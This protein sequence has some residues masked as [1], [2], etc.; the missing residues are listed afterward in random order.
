MLRLL[1]LPFEW[2]LSEPTKQVS[3]RRR[4]A[5]GD[6]HLLPPV[7][8]HGD[9]DVVRDGAD[10][11]EDVEDLVAV[12]DDVEHPGSPLLRHAADVEPGARGVGEAHD[13]L[14]AQRQVAGGVAPVEPE[15]V[16]RRD[17][18]R[19]AH[20][21]EQRRAEAAVARGRAGRGEQRGHHQRAQRR[22][23]AQVGRPR[24]RV[25]EEGVVHRRHEGGDDHHGDARV[26][27]LPEHR[28]GAPR[29][30]RQQVR[31]RADG[32]ARHGPH[33][34]H[35]PRPPRHT[36]QRCPGVVVPRLAL[37]AIIGQSKQAIS[38][39][40]QRWPHSQQCH[41]SASCAARAQSSN[42]KVPDSLLGLN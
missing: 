36:G 12:A 13:D 23:G 3:L 24:R 10:E 28:A 20:G 16:Q 14:E 34:E 27:Q 41:A 30:A 26:V 11:H 38:Q 17:D 6:G 18:A 40:K 29:V 21:Q 39:S 33:Q 25:A 5:T 7:D 9:G 37:Q 8:E 2:L 15:R 42:R 32:E 19:Q 4:G 35:R 22:D 31:R 1:G